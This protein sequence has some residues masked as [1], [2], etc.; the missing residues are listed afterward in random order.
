MDLVQAIDNYGDGHNEKPK[1]FIWP[2]SANDI[3]EKA[4]RARKD[5]VNVQGV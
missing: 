5:L 1:P 3:L 2:A 4:K